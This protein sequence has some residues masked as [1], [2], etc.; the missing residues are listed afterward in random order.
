MPS[1]NSALRARSNA[2]SPRVRAVTAR[3]DAI[4]NDSLY[5]RPSAARIKSPGDSAKS[6]DSAGK[7]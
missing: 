3:L 6:S 1:S 7:I 2:L 5:G 4:P